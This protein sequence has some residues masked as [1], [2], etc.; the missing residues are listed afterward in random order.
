[1]DHLHT[2]I[3]SVFLAGII[4]FFI[5]VSDNNIETSQIITAVNKA[6]VNNTSI[7]LETIQSWLNISK[8]LTNDHNNLPIKIA[9]QLIILDLPNKKSSAI[10]KNEDRIV[11]IT[12]KYWEV[13]HSIESKQGEMLYRPRN[14]EKS[15]ANTSAPCGHYQ[16]S[17][18]A[19]KDIGCT[20][21]QCK[22]DRENLKKS[23]AMSQTLENINLNRLAKKGYNHFPDYQKYLIHQ[24]GATGI[25]LI[26]DAQDGRYELGKKLIKNMANNS[27]YSFKNL[28]S[29]GSKL[30][31]QQFLG[32]W[33]N[34]WDAEIE[35][36]FDKQLKQ[37]MAIRQYLL[38]AN[39]TQ[40]N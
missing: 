12:P 40:T 15:C 38:V 6:S 20:T 31:A 24:Q 30:A 32:Y 7:S 3:I 13:V 21:L 26:L 37:Q 17:A 34:M 36:I 5:P 2:I 22:M 16:I 14:K 29:M 35:M 9:N 27:S 33:E 19:L 39:N 8:P 23:L 11:L 28:K 1:M 18:Q 10:S 25:K 4:S